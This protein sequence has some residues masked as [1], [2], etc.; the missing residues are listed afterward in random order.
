[1]RNWFYILTVVFFAACNSSKNVTTAPTAPEK[2]APIWVSSRPNSGFKFVGIGFAEK[3]AGSNYQLEAKKNALFD[4]VSEIKVD[5]NSNSLLYTVQNNNTFNENFTSLIQLSNT[6]N[7]EGYQ[8][9]D[10]YENEK[11]YWVYYQLDKA[12][13]AQQKEKKKLQ[14]INAASALILSAFSDEKANDFT[15]ALR[16]RI[17][18]FGTLSPYLND[19][20]VFD[21][22]L[23]GGVANVFE[24]TALIQKQLQAIQILT[25][26]QTPTVKAFQASYS[27]INYY[28]T[29]DGKQ[30]LYGFPFALSSEDDKMVINDM[31][32]TD[33]NGILSVKLNKAEAV[34]QLFS[35]DLNPDIRQ[36]MGNDSIG[37]AGIKIL[38][39][40]IQTPSLKVQV[41]VSAITL[42]LNTSEN[43][44]GKP[45]GGNNIERFIREK[46]ASPEFQFVA[47]P[48]DAD[49]LIDCRADVVEDLSSNALK[50]N[51]ELTLAELRINLNLKNKNGDP[52]YTNAVNEIYGYGGT[53][54]SAGLNAYSSP[55]FK[56]KLSEAVFFL[57]RKIVVY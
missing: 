54:E 24:L 43:N 3:K 35:F 18:A 32:R 41:Y 29:F 36:L 25:T 8:M 16:K 5:I 15:S 45:T 19:E 47:N 53:L 37:M 23:T 12:E 17:Q 55:K 57:K 31:A 33:A 51:F 20:V 28:L 38:N 21:P 46:F 6:D 4:L 49:Y 13:Y 34:N 27:P 11:Q 44:L 50:R 39:R 40:F 1:M 10:S 2:P 42:Y 30:K 26:V 9:I 52:L 56:A 7:I 14:T 48:Q 22:K